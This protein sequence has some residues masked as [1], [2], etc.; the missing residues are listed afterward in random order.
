MIGVVYSYLSFYFLIWVLFVMS[1]SADT[2][3]DRIRMKGEIKKWRNLTIIFAVLWAIGLMVRVFDLNNL[4]K[5]Y[6]AS[7]DIKGIISQSHGR[8]KK[9]EF[10]KDDERVQAV[11][12]HINSPGGT[13]VGGEHLYNSLRK[14]AEKKPVVAVMGTV[15]A[16]A[17]YMTA[18]A[19]DKIFA[20]EGTMTG[21][22]GVMMQAAEV[23]ELAE[24]MGINF[25][26]IK[27]SD[28]KGTPSFTEKMT[29][30]AEKA[31]QD[32]IDDG[33]DYFTDLVAQRRS[34]SKEE[35]LKLADGRIYTGRQAVNNKLIDAIGKESDAIKWLEKEKNIEEGLK[36][37]NVLIKDKD[38]MFDMLLNGSLGFDNPYLSQ[39]F[40]SSGFVA[41]WK[42]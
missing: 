37:K 5:E 12:V 1:L 35:V 42:P 19:A 31:V 3:L 23:T 16:S 32:G 9:L 29:P 33:Y 14:I 2:L 21:S 10:L 24:K 25:I 20:S 7:V 6:I 26:T 8:D 41:M 18:I 34:L 40:P 30:K 11:I 4:K 22:I 39:I 27:S 13:M 38:S 36:V 15:A 28:L 17:G